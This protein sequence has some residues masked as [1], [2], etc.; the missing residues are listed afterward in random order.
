MG[1]GNGSGREFPKGFPGSNC[2]EM[3]NTVSSSREMVTTM[4]WR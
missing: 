4:C 3:F 1:F 2:H